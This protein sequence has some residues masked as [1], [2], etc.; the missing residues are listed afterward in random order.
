MHDLSPAARYATHALV[1]TGG[2]ACVAGAAADVLDEPTL[3]AAFAH[4][5]R[6]LAD[7]DLVAWVAG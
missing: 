3:S 1:F 4:R 6:R 2:S 7:G 5:V